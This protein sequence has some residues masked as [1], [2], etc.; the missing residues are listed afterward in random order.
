MEGFGLGKREGGVKDAD[1]Y[2]YE[3]IKKWALPYQL[4][5]VIVTVCVGKDS[6]LDLKQN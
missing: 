6:L 3:R 5:V 4:N 1:K 2:M